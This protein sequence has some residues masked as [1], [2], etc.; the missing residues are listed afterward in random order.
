MKI[1]VIGFRRDETKLKDIA[2]WIGGEIFSGQ[3]YIQRGLGM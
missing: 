3:K 2:S 1:A